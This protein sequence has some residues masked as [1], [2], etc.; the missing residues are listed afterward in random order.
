MKKYF[1]FV[2]FL[3][4]SFNI[5]AAG[6]QVNSESVKAY[7]T[8]KD[9]YEAKDY[10]KALK[11]AEDAILYRKNESE[12]EQK[13][14]NDALNAQKV[15]AVGKEIKNVLVILE[16]RKEKEALGIINY[17]IKIKG[18]EF[19]NNNIDNITKYINEIKE[20]PEAYR[21]IGDIYQLEG[22]YDFAE[23][24]YNL[25][26][27]NADIL[28]IPDERYDILFTLAQIS[29]LKEDYASMEIRLLSILVE[30]PFYK[31]E[32]LFNAMLGTIK[33]NKPNSVEKYF[34][35]YRANSYYCLNTYNELVEYYLDVGENEKALRLASLTVLT[36]YTK[37]YE[38]LKN[39]NPDFKYT[40]IASFFQELSFYND[41]IEWGRKNNV[42]KSFNLLA[43]ITHK[44]GY[45]VYS[46][47]LLNV[48]INY[49]PDEYWKKEAEYQLK[50]FN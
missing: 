6:T 36:G 20:F 3:F 8:A 17:Y 30:D 40:D 43:E 18:I 48:L 15:L 11:F 1:A 44:Y 21:L 45:D 50:N 22:E 27:D 13:V 33:S 14:L 28:D 34:T 2:I 10:G 39:R 4:F 46:R 38:I 31:D 37:I 42:W 23:D 7:R 24:Y 41:I 12:Y 49:M 32:V 19:F 5:F 16:Q 25:A 47:E 29:K 26:L 9:Y 35:L